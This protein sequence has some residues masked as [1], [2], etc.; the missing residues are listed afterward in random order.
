MK[1]MMVLGGYTHMIDVVETAKRMGFY[2]IVVDRDPDSPAKAH[3]D[4]AFDIST[5][6]TERLAEISRTEEVGGVINAFDDFNTWQARALCEKLGLPYYAT[7][8]QLAICSDKERFKAYCRTYGVP[9]IEEYG[10]GD[11]LKGGAES[12]IRF[13]VIVKP[14]DSY[15]SQGISVCYSPEELEKAYAKANQRSRSGNAIIERFVDNSHGVEMYY[16]VKEGNVILTGVA[17]R[18][19]HKVS[20]EHPPLPTATVF[21]S[22]HRELFLEKLDGKIRT[23]IRGMGIQNG[24]LFFQSLFEEGEFFLYE[25]GFRLSGEKHYQ[26]IE[27][28]TGV[29]LLEMMLDFA[30]G[31]NLDAYPIEQFDNGYAKFPACNL[32]VLLNAGE[33]REVNGLEHILDMPQVVSFTGL[34][35]AGDQV[36]ATGNYG[37]MLGR[38]NIVCKDTA[39]FHAAINEI[40][41]ALE[42]VSTEG[43][44]MIAARC[45]PSAEKEI[46]ARCY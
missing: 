30:A 18:Y 26:L 8:E 32:A 23:M 38:F 15:A 4:K 3:A 44:D 37:Q 14:V 31:G 7:K 2:T 36:E 17:D 33:I 43:A 6:E 27:K 39:D 34:K 9:V 19:V 25:V 29:N 24:V 22:Q 16:T 1:K 21:P 12:K 45:H 10:I 41:R 35:G 5:D 28:Q 42:V 20:E 13:P 46:S 40:N 11:L